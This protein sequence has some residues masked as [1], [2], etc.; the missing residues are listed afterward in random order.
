MYFSEENIVQLK[1]DHS[2][3]D[4]SYKSLLMAY[5]T[6]EFSSEQAAEF[7]RH[8]FMRRV[9]TLKR[10]IDNV[11]SICP[12]EQN[13]KPSSEELSDLAINLQSFVLNVFGCLDN[14]AWVLVKE[15]GIHNRGKDLPPSKIGL[16]GKYKG[17][18]KFE[19]VRQSL[20][21]EFRDYLVRMDEWFEYLENFRHALAHRVPLYV[22][23]YVVNEEEADKE[24]ELENRRTEVLIRK[25][26]DEYER[27]SEELEANGKFVPW[28]THSFSEGSKQ[29]VFHAQIIADWNTVVELSQKF[30]DE[31]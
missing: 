30:L 31:V 6:K 10:C 18:Y 2:K 13:T 3:I 22:P 14:L 8:G 24:R 29:V 7:A 12:P 11:Y 16:L 23:P 9:K 15:K 26:F 1:D 28:M 19:T 21:Q 4:S 27:L 20:S 25:D 5:A 17:D